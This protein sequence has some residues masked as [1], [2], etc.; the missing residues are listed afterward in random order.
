[1]EISAVMEETGASIDTQTDAIREIADQ[2]NLLALNASIEAA[3]AGESGRGFAVVADEIKK[4]SEV[5]STE[6]DKIDNLVWAV[7]ESVSVLSTKSED[8]IHFLDEDVLN[9]YYKLE[10]IVMNYKKDAN[11]YSDVSS[12]LGATSEE[13]SAS[14]SNI[15]GILDS[16]RTGQEELDVGVQNVNQSLQEITMDSEN[17]DRETKNIIESIHSLGKTI[18]KFEV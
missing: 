14:V 16:I 12:A 1:M 2:T 7:I 10:E 4:L 5:T 18:D 3:R 11:Y 17:A 9:D 15:T 6:I 13:L 8:I